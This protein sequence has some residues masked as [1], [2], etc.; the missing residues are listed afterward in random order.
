[1]N[2]RQ[3]LSNLCW[4][5]IFEESSLHSIKTLEFQKNCW[6]SLI[7]GR[8]LMTI[9]LMRHGLH[10]TMEISCRQCTSYILQS[11]TQFGGV[12]PSLGFL[13]ST[14]RYMVSQMYFIAF[15]SRGLSW[16]WKQQA[17]FFSNHMMFW[18]L[19]GG[20]LFCWNRFSL[21]PLVQDRS[22]CISIIKNV[23]TLLASPKYL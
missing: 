21:Y 12:F 6:T 23:R 3:R 8:S 20:T 15:R 22:E 13:C 14:A 2:I 17:E 18:H 1:M 4:L 10:E 11:S 9:K 5:P 16:N 19:C 7:L